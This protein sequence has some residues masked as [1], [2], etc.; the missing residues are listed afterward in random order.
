MKHKALIITITIILLFTSFPVAWADDEGGEI[1][2]PPVVV[3]NELSNSINELVT[4]IKATQENSNIEIVPDNTTITQL[5]LSSNDTSGLHS[6]LLSLIGDYNPIAKDYTYQSSNGYIS[7]SI[8]IQPDY[9]WIAS[10]LIFAILLYCSFR[11]LGMALG[12]SR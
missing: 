12:G 10:A 8:D 1:I 4:Q 11:L 6:I 5:R 9:S 3:D 7:H 2:A